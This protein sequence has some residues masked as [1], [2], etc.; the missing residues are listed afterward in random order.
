MELKRRGWKWGFRIRL[1][2]FGGDTAYKGPRE[3]AKSRSLGRIGRIY[4]WNVL[5]VWYII[6]CDHDE[7]IYWNVQQTFCTF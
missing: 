7:K 4:E 3:I 6:T 2:K 5:S 1:H